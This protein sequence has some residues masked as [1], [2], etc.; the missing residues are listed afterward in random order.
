MSNKEAIN[1]LFL[2]GTSCKIQ[3]DPCNDNL[4]IQDI[5]KKVYLQIENGELNF[6][7]DNMHTICFYNAN[8]KIEE[9]DIVP[10]GTTLNA[11]V[12]KV[13]CDAWKGG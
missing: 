8:E 9:Y 7:I 1:I 10:G 12:E 5:Q 11:I 2:N 13:K 6:H 3:F 4:T